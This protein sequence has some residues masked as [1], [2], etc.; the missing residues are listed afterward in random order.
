MPGTSTLPGL[1]KDDTVFYQSDESRDLYIVLSG[2]VR[3]SLIN[4]E[5]EELILAVFNVGDFFGEYQS[6]DGVA[7][8]ATIIVEEPATLGV[9]KRE[10][11]LAI[12]KENPMFVID[13]LAIVAKRLRETDTMVGS[14]VFLDVTER[15]AKFLIHLARTEGVRDKNGFY[16]LRHHL[17]RKDL[18][19][20]IGASGGAIT[21]SLKILDF[22]KIITEKKGYL[23]ISPTA[24]KD[25]NLS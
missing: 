9:L 4:E 11:F 6:A 12:A 7:R 17:I 21:K 16:R 25:L 1:K 8:S 14:L 3:A 15:L 22:R 18:A 2:R 5:G 19:A 23:I 20:R 13:V 24:E 10:S